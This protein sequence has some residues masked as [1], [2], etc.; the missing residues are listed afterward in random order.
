MKNLSREL[1]KFRNSLKL[2]QNKFGERFGF[3]KGH[4]SK[5]ETGKIK[6]PEKKIV[7]KIQSII[8]GT[9]KEK[10]SKKVAKVIIAVK[11]PTA[12]SKKA[13]TISKK[14]IVKK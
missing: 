13:K 3:C 6:N 4:I 12:I 1:K 8:A 11:K 2:S 9:F 14:K 5:L 10:I 7:E